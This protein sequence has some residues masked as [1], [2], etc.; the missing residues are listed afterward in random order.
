MSGTEKIR[1]KE[2]RTN[3]AAEFIAAQVLKYPN[4]VRIRARRMMMMK[5]F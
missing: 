4:Q 1:R 2:K 5:I 3:E